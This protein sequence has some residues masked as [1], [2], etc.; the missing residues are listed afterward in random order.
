M[1]PYCHK[2]FKTYVNC[3]KHMKIHKHELV[4]RVQ[5]L[6][7]KKNIKIG[8]VINNEILLY[9]FLQQL[10]QQKIRIQEQSSDKLNLKENSKQETALESSSS[11]VSITTI[12]STI[13]T[14]IATTTTTPAIVTTS[15]STFSDN[16]V[17]SRLGSVELSFQ[18][19][20]GSEFSQT[21]PEFQNIAE[22]KEKVRAVLPTNCDATTF[23]NRTF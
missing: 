15:S 9:F 7:G 12:N 4:Q 17:L 21:F 1:C 20:L 14:N 13:T 2:T 22:E 6:A 11:S 16:L 3:R 10:E 18:S 23:I 5:Y 8:F 19:Q